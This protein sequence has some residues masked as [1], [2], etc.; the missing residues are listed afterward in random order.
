[1]VHREVALKTHLPKKKKK[2]TKKTP[3]STEKEKCNLDMSLRVVETESVFSLLG[4]TFITAPHG[5]SNLRTLG[6]CVEE[7]LPALGGRTR[8]KSIW[9][10]DIFKTCHIC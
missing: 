2:Q 6:R 3:T 8:S 7:K 1:M 9:W 5:D 10:M 4:A